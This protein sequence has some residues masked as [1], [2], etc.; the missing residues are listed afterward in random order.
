MPWKESQTMDL[1]V[2]LIHDYDE[3]HSISALA[4]I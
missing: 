1:R 3:G 4:E 2:Q